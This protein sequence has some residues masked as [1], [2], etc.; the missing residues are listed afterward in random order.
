M[1]LSSLQAPARCVVSSMSGNHAAVRRLAAFGLLPGCRLQVLRNG[2]SA[3]VIEL[4]GG[5][6]ALSHEL[7]A[8]VIVSDKEDTI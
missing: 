4:R 2:K 3:L 6:L 8:V 5:F 7:A 1:T